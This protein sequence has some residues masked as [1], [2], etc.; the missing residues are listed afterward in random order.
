MQGF[1]VP[2][3]YL[4]VMDVTVHPVITEKQGLP[5]PSLVARPDAEHHPE[6]LLVCGLT[7]YRIRKRTETID[8]MWFDN[9]T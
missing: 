2:R 6:P 8:S 5:T 4:T 1:D 3:Q 7:Q 9:E